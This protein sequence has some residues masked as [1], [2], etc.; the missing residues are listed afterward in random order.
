MDTALISEGNKQ[1]QG[2]S[3]SEGNSRH[4]SGKA[5][6]NEI[7]EPAQRPKTVK[8]LQVSLNN[9]LFTP[10]KSCLTANYAEEEKGGKEKDGFFK[11]IILN[12]VLYVYGTEGHS[13]VATKAMAK[14]VFEGREGGF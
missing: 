10:C 6:A 13:H 7:H 1:H 2:K 5:K 8:A 4:G 14:S 12:R 3:A 11:Q 9:S